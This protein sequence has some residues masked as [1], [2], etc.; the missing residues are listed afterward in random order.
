[1]TTTDYRAR[2][3]AGLDDAVRRLPA[4]DPRAAA[5][6]VLHLIETGPRAVDC[7]ECHADPDEPCTGLD[8]G[9][10]HRA[11]GRALRNQTIATLRHALG[12]SYG[13]P[14]PAA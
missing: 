13:D 8:R 4:P 11:R 3:D 12:L 2:L 5:L 1:M 7:P 9:M 6:C 14:P 10:N